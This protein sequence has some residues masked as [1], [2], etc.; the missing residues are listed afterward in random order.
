MP[1]KEEKFVNE[2][3]GYIMH[4]QY[5]LAKYQFRKVEP[6][7]N[8]QIELKMAQRLAIISSKVPSHI[9]VKV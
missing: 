2:M 7:P 9:D 5:K 4:L 8:L 3:R 6:P 1:H